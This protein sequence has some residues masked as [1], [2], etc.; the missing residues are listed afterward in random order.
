MKSTKLLGIAIA[1]VIF[2]ASSTASA[3]HFNCGDVHGTRDGVGLSGCGR[4]R[5]PCALLD[6]CSSSNGGHP[7]HGNLPACLDDC[8][9]NTGGYC[10]RIGTCTDLC[11]SC[12]TF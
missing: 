6:S 1:S 9:A 3:D 2:L 11:N 10:T 7:D 8:D 4:L 5:L 12:F